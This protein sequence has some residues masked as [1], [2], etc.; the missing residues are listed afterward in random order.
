M[1]KT[2]LPLCTQKTQGIN[3]NLFLTKLSDLI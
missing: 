1:K 3:T 2:A